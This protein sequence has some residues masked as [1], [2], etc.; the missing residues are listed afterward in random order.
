MKG[1]TKVDQK[2]D[3]QIRKLIK[4][5][6]PEVKCLQGNT[7]VVLANPAG[8]IQGMTQL[9]QGVGNAQR[10]GLEQTHG[11]IEERM[12]IINVNNLGGE[13][14]RVIY[15]KW[16]EKA[17]PTVANVLE[18][19][20]VNAVYN[21]VPAKKHYQILSDKTYNLGS[22]LPNSA[23]LPFNW[24]ASFSKK[25]YGKAYYTGVTNNIADCDEGHV[26]RITIGSSANVEYETSYVYTYTDE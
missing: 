24:T 10:I 19:V 3:K 22:S 1:K 17:P 23:A 9:A 13:V 12:S 20:A 4:D 7:N 14:F 16:N 8:T 5:N 25:L 15:F 18:H 2:Q 21:H 11:H 26:Y 6:K